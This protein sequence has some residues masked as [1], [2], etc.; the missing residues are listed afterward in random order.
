M[1]KKKLKFVNTAKWKFHLEQRYVHIAEKNR[2]QM[3]A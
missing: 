3:D 1:K 2:G